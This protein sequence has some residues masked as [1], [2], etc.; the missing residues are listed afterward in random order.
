[1]LADDTL[2]IDAASILLRKNKAGEVVQMRAIDGALITKYIDENGWTPQNGDPAYA[3]LWY[4]IPMVDLSTDDL[5][6]RPWNPRTNKLYGYSKVEQAIQHITL[7]QRRLEWQLA[8]Y[9]SS[10]IPEGIMIVPP[11]ATPEQIERQQNWLNSTLAGNIGRR[12]QLRLVQGFNIDDKPEQILFPKLD[13]LIMDE[14]D[15]MLARVLCFCFSVSPH[16]LQKMMN[17]ATAQTS[18]ESSEEEG[19]D[20]IL[21][22]LAD[23]MNYIIQIKMGFVDYEFA[24]MEPRET[25]IAKQALADEIY[26]KN[27]IKTINQVLIAMGEDPSDNPDCDKNLIITGQGTVEVGKQLQPAGGGRNA[28]SSGT[29]V[30]PT[31]AV[32]T[33][34]GKI[35][36]CTQHNEFTKTCRHCLIEN[37]AVAVAD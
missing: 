21:N 4:N 3:Q 35:P 10:N 27:G 7:G 8:N 16:A 13:K 1:M 11:T 23:T 12:T 6:Y 14:T 25:D 24:W 15:D 37:L 5:V 2:V 32:E 36:K 9:D 26:V 31:R 28:N 17:R 29:N 20:P 33:P 22:Y 30:P 19:L 34:G 18:Q